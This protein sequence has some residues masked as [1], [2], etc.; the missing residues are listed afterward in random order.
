LSDL[1]TPWEVIEK[2][3]AAAAEGD[4]VIVFYNPKSHRRDWQLD[5]A[6]DVLLRSRP[7]TTPVGIVH[8]AMREGQEVS[9]TT[10]ED[11]PRQ[12]VDMQTVVIVGNSNTYAYGPFMITPRGY[13]AKYAP[14]DAATGAAEGAAKSA[15]QS[16]SDAAA[17]EERS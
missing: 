6:R 5:A 13:L 8:K 11:L 12:P 16:P 3:V 10:L 15:A 17:P 1:L 2:R 7:G 9:I 4:F 14:E